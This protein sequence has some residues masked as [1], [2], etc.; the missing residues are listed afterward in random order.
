MSYKPNYDEDLVAGSS[1]VTNVSGRS[2]HDNILI[3]E[4]AQRAVATSENWLLARKTNRTR[5]GSDSRE[6]LEEAGFQ[7]V[8]EHDDLFYKVKPPQGWTKQTQGY[9]TYVYDSE[10]VERFSQFFKGAWY[11]RDAFLNVT[12][13]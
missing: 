8:S 9:W 6:I 4:A 7:V 5:G 3:E 1:R 13:R 11:D 2:P 10:G 12:L